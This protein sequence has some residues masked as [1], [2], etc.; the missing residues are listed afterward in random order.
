MVR[1]LIALM[2]VV[3]LLPLTNVVRA[4]SRRVDVDPSSY[5]A[6]PLKFA[7]S[8]DPEQ[9]QYL[10]YDFIWRSFIALNWPNDPLKVQGDTITSGVRGKPDT[11]IQ[12]LSTHMSGAGELPLTVWETYKE[13]WEV[14]PAPDKWQASDE[15]NSVR[16]LPPHAS[17]SVRRKLGFTGLTGY[18]VDVNQPDFFPHLTGPLY[19]RNGNPLVY[20]VAVNRSFFEYVRYFHYYNANKQIEAVRNYLEGK[21]DRTSFQRPPFGNPKELAG[22]LSDLPPYAQTGMIDVKAA[23]RVLEKSDQPKRYLWRRMVVGFDKK[24]RPQVRRMGLV[25]LHILRWTPNGYDATQG[26]DGAFVA[27]TFEQVDNVTPSVDGDGKIVSPS[28]N[29]GQMPTREELE[30]GF[31]GK[32]P[33]QIEDGTPYSPNKSL[34]V[35]VY[36]AAS[37][38]LPAAVRKINEIYQSKEPVKGSVLQYYQ[39]IGTQNHHQGAVDFETAAGRE[40]NGH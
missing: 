9:Q 8:P 18:A 38:R 33:P 6:M 1:I 12:I 30:F 19:D 22:Y 3:A 10:L 34:R 40:R 29:D 35:N 37:Q 25:A 31:R 39:L 20:E 27:S 23:W 13:P 28:F 7:T 16:P 32:V 4:Q 26:V 14:F 11:S 5:A 15:W 36:R 2:L 21:R 17:K 24:G